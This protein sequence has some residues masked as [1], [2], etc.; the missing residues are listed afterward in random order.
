MTK[1]PQHDGGCFKTGPT[2]PQT[3]QSQARHAILVLDREGSGAD[4]RPPMKSRPTSITGSRNRAGETGHE[5]SFWILRSKSGFGPSPPMLPTSSGGLAAFQLYGNGWSSKGSSK[6]ARRNLLAPRRLFTPLF[7]GVGSNPPLLYSASSLP[8]S[9]WNIATI[10]GFF[11]SAIRF[12]HGSDQRRPPLPDPLKLDHLTVEE[13]ALLEALEKGAKR[14][15][16]RDSRW[17]RSRTG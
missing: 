9:A 14:C 8:R 17:S 1:H 6:K 5:R 16:S 2:L 11:D 3:L 12:A 10:A 4:D 15:G 13:F 7:A